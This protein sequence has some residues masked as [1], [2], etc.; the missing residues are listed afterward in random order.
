VRVC[1][2]GEDR[3][4]SLI[5]EGLGI[6]TGYFVDV[7]SGGVYSNTDWLRVRGWQ[8]LQIDAGHEGSTPAEIVKHV[9]MENVMESLPDTGSVQIHF[10]SLD[11][12]GMEYWLLGKILES[13][14]LLPLVVM[15]EYNQGK[16]AQDDVQPYDPT[17]VW[18]HG[19]HGHGASWRALN[20]LMEGHGYILCFK[21]LVNCI[22]V[23]N[24]DGVMKVLLPRSEP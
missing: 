4:L 20:A 15:T 10:L 6:S 17:Y 14:K 2:F 23:R 16:I 3:L 12:D 18:P 21:N 19:F 7:G 8:G 13:S 9:T 22:F 1:E 11:V 5:F 24:I